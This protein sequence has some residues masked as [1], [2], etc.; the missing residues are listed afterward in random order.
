MKKSASC[1]CCLGWLH[2]CACDAICGDMVVLG[3]SVHGRDHGYRDVILRQT[4]GSALWLTAFDWG[5]ELDAVVKLLLTVVRVWCCWVTAEIDAD[6]VGNVLAAHS[7]GRHTRPEC[8]FGCW[9]E[10]VF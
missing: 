1:Y 5:W 8:K 7:S 2:L 6:V 4:R 3:Q 9:H 10:G